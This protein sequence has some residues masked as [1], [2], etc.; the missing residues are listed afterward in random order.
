MTPLPHPYAAQ[1]QAQAQSFRG[2][3]DANVTVSE[4]D[5]PGP[6]NSGSGDI[7]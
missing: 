4:K 1:A 5:I 7:E 6:R 2:P 3:V